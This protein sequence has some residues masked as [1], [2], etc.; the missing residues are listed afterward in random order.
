MSSL[1]WDGIKE[2]YERDFS[3]SLGAVD[4]FSALSWDYKYF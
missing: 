2:I 1:P 4:I 3:A